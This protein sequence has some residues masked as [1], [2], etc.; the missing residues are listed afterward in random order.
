M[1]SVVYTRARSNG[2]CLIG[3]ILTIRN[4][5]LSLTVPSLLRLL[6]Q[7]TA[8]FDN[9]LKI[10]WIQLLLDGFRLVFWACWFVFCPGTL[11]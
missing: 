9:L 2:L 7:L 10:Q 3:N 5:N 1:L 4:W 6:S 8:F 11:L